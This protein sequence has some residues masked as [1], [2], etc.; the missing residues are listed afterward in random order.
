MRILDLEG[1]LVH[2]RV[3]NGQSARFETLDPPLSG[4]LAARL[5]EKGVTKLYRHQARAV[6]KIRQGTH[7]VLVSGTASGKTLC[8]QIPIAERILSQP[9]STALLMFPTKALAQDQLR[10]FRDLRI[11]GLNAATYDGDVTSDARPGVRKHSNVI[12]TNPDMLHFGILPLSRKVG[13]VLSS[14]AVRR[15]R[16][17]ALSPGNVRQPHVP[18]HPPPAT[19]RCSLR[20]IPNVRF[21]LGHDR[22]PR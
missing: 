18:H 8:Y 13:R 22:Q 11:P 17:D 2:H 4:P 1:D 15:H 12:F 9:K 3:V 6:R 14:T 7:T 21:R 19:N 5:A 10:S 16:R 20:F